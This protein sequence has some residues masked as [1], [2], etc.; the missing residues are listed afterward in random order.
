MHKYKSS[1]VSTVSGSIVHEKR[2]YILFFTRKQSFPA[3]TWILSGDFV[4]GKP[5]A[6]NDNEL[7]L[8]HFQPVNIG[9]RTHYKSQEDCSPLLKRIKPYLTAHH[10]DSSH[11]GR[12]SFDRHKWDNT[13]QA[14]KNPNFF[15]FFTYMLI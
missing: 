11:W 3:L 2:V 5:S 15:V 14:R 8:I 4:I 9:H 10:P 6:V 13:S 1:T 12:A 7:W